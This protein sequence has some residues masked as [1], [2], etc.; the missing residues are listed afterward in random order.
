M[1]TVDPFAAFW[2]LLT[3]KVFNCCSIYMDP[4]KLYIT[5]QIDAHTI[6][7]TKK[8]HNVPVKLAPNKN[9]DK[10]KIIK[11]STSQDFIYLFFVLFCLKKIFFYFSE[12]NYVPATK[13]QVV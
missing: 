1:I 4:L 6:A 7:R 3:A 2:K 5:T 13:V 10:N 9:N 8:F 11:D 12:N